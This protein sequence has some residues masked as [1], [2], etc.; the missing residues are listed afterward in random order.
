MLAAA[1]T[2]HMRKKLPETMEMIGTHLHG[3][4]ERE[5]G[6]AHV[7]VQDKIGRAPLARPRAQDPGPGQQPA[8]AVLGA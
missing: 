2:V 7:D 5:T 4:A 6:P 1:H 3:G 8:P